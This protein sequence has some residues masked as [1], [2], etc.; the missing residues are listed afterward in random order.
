MEYATKDQH[1]FE[2]NR[3]HERERPR[4]INS[5]GSRGRGMNSVETKQ[6]KEQ[7]KKNAVGIIQRE[8]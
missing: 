8:K 5:R 4:Q 3:Y 6:Y 2:E 7:K 1:T